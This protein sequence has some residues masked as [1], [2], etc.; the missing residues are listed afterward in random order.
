MKRKFLD[1][2]GCEDRWDRWEYGG[3]RGE[4]FKAQREEW[5]FDARET[6]ALNWNFYQWLYERLIV[7]RDV[8]GEV[9]DLTF[10]KFEWKGEER[11]QL[12]LINLL[13]SELK[14]AISDEAN[15]YKDEDC[16]RVQEIGELWAVILP[17]MW[18]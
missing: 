4:R 9:V 2:I 13:I 8:G 16:A 11:T 12:E 15:I 3:G 17:A 10:N 7:Y 14:W 6:F 5:G 18:W 1:E